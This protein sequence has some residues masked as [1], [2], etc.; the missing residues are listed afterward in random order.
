MAARGN[1][2]K[3]LVVRN[4]ANKVTVACHMQEDSRGQGIVVCVQEQC[5]NDLEFVKYLG[6][7]TRTRLQRAGLQERRWMNTALLAFLPATKR[8]PEC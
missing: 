3:N 8:F 6:S 4:V 2:C 1:F 5:G 7:N